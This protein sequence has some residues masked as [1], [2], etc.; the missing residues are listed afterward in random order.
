MGSIV[1]TKPLEVLEMDFTQLVPAEFAYDAW[2][3]HQ[4]IVA[5]PTRDQKVLTVAK[6]LV[7]EWFLVYG[8]PQGIH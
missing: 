7:Q 8:V 2:C 3:F 4:I 6:A 1:A 5:I